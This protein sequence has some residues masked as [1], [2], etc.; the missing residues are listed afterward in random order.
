V[1]IK[2][3]CFKFWKKR[4]FQI[5]CCNIMSLLRITAYNKLPFRCCIKVSDKPLYQKCFQS[6]GGGGGG[7][8][9]EE[10]NDF[11]SNFTF[12]FLD[13]I[14]IKH[15]KKLEIRKMHRRFL[16]IWQYKQ[17]KLYNL[18]IGNE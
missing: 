6:K 9:G 4:S 5:C 3:N 15:K 11:L 18:G 7:G 8:G 1:I 13:F 17:S 2:F 16:I 14:L 10:E 12:S